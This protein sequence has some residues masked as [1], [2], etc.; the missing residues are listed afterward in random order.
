MTSKELAV[1]FE[2]LATELNKDYPHT[3]CLLFAIAGCL[4]MSAK[5]ERVHEMGLYLVPFL[6]DRL[7]KLRRELAVM[8]GDKKQL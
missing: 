5:E 7:A 8:E 2:G 6:K 3:S 1:K 4:Q